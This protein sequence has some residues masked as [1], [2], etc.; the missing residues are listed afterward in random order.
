MR[1]SCYEVTAE[2][3][4]GGKCGGGGGGRLG[5]VSADKVT[6]GEVGVDF[7]LSTSIQIQLSQFF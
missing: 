6:A 5:F 3:Y 7:E 4:Q 1:E 2:I